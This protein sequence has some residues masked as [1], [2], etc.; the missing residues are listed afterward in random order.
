MDECCR[1]WG[2]EDEETLRK[3]YPCLI[4]DGCFGEK[5]PEGGRL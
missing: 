4:T 5:L 2:K 1:E 3:K